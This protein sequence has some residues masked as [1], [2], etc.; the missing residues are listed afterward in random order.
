MRQLCVAVAAVE[1]LSHCCTPGVPA[2]PITS[3]SEPRDDESS[4]LRARETITSST[5]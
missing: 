1:V 4:S 2:I 5:S 3:L